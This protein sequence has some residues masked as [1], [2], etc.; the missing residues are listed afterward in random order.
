MIKGHDKAIAAIS[1]EAKLG[2]GEF[3]AWAEKTLPTIHHH[4]QMAETLEGATR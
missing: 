2:S 4:H 3:K 1:E